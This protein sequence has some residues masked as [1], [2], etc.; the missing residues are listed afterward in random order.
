MGKH[1]NRLLGHTVRRSRP[2]R[3][4]HSGQLLPRLDIRECNILTV[5]RRQ[6]R[7]R[8]RTGNEPSGPMSKTIK[9]YFRIIN[10]YTS[11]KDMCIFDIIN[12]RCNLPYA[13][14]RISEINFVHSQRMLDTHPQR[15]SRQSYCILQIIAHPI[16]A[17]FSHRLTHTHTIARDTRPSPNF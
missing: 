13:G 5:S 11:L 4:L 1:W 6:L 9:L 8:A 16:R 15:L 2:S 7:N 10:W 3:N 17:D 12:T 14:I